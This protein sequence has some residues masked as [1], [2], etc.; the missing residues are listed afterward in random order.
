ME[1]CLLIF[2]E[3]AD[4]V[5]GRRTARHEGQKTPEILIPVLCG[6]VKGCNEV[7]PYLLT[8]ARCALKENQRL[9]SRNDRSA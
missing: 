4:Q 9:Y 6:R 3:L 2:E 8:L 5:A 7:S 1:I